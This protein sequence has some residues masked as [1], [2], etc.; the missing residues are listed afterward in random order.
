[1]TNRLL[2]RVANLLLAEDNE[3]DVMLMREGFRRAKLQVNLHH[4]EDG[5][6]CLQFLRRQGQYADAPTPDLILLDV[7][8]PVMSGREVMR[9]ISADPSL[10]HLPVVVLTTSPDERDVLE[11]YR[12]RCSSYIVKPV[13]FPKFIK[14]VQDLTN[15]WFALVVLPKDASTAAPPE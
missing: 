4:V 2:G 10:S 8:M 12:L 15:Y 14:V 3:D 5:E 1:M 13:D 7:N 11:L 6:R 9:E